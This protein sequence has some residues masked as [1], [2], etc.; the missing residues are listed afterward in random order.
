MISTL[1]LPKVGQVCLRGIVSDV[2]NAN[3]V[4]SGLKFS[5]IPPDL[6]SGTSS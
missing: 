3:V 1:E 6:R 2:V 5:R 4:R